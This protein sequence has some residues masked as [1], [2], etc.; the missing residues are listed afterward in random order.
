MRFPEGVP[1]RDAIAETIAIWIKAE[2]RREKRC[3]KETRLGFEQLFDRKVVELNIE[4]PLPEDRKWLKAE[5]GYRT[6]K[7]SRP[8]ACNSDIALADI[9]RYNAGLGDIPAP[10]VGRT[11]EN[12]NPLA[13]H[14]LEKIRKGLKKDR[15][16]ALL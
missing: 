16:L 14:T 3:R 7:K 8:K 10:L 15:Q 6:G 11:G 13:P 5:V 2:L 12:Y 9:E 1:D 4:F